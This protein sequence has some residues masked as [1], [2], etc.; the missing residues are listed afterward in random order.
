MTAVQKKTIMFDDNYWMQ[1]ALVLAGEAALKGEVP[2]GAI[3]VL[4]NKVIGK[5][6]N[7]PISTCDP[8]A[9]A[10]IVA[11]RDAAKAI[12]NYRI[13][14]ACLYVTLEPCT[15]CAGAMIHSRIKRLVYGADEPKAGV[16]NSQTNL[17]AAPY[18]NHKI[19]VVTGVCDHECSEIIS[20]FFAK[21]RRHVK[22]PASL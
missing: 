6:F 17:L 2:V 20:T 12:N 11:L 22:N 8:T 15:M 21:K 5:G 10:E 18:L 7:Q 19:A 1:Q 14:N 13:I 4:D 16:I 3:V 9:H